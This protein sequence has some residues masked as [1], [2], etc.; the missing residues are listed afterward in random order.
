MICSK[1]YFHHATSQFVFPHG[2]RYQIQVILHGCQALSIPHLIYHFQPYSL[3]SQSEQFAYLLFSGLHKPSL[4]ILI[5]LFMNSKL[6]LLLSLINLTQLYLHSN[7]HSLSS[8]THFAFI[9]FIKFLFRSA[10]C[11]PKLF[12]CV[13]LH[14]DLCHSIC[15]FRVMV[16]IN[17]TY[18]NRISISGSLRKHTHC[19][20]VVKSC[21][22][23]ATVCRK[24]I[25]YYYFTI[26]FK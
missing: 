23:I 7:M 24:D 5:Y 21:Q 19:Y 13:C 16:L 15:L 17:Q 25:F 14:Y 12:T 1:H 3:S 26:L 6:P 10:L 9:L 8:H 2:L 11:V 20:R 4:L 22:S 18:K